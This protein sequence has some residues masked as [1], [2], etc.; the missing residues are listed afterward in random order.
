M[1]F[2]TLALTFFLATSAATSLAEGPSVRV[3]SIDDC[4]TIAIEHNLDIQV[5]Q[6]QPELAGFSLS[7]IYGNYEPSLT[8]SGERAKLETPDGITTE[9]DSVRGAVGGFL[10]WGMNYSVGLRMSESSGSRPG[11]QAD[12]SSPILTTNTLYPVNGPAIDYYGTN[13]PSLATRNPFDTSTANAGFFELRQPLLRDFLIDSTR[14]QIYIDKN[15]LK[16][17]ELELRNQIMLTI[18]E[19]E[20]AYYDLIYAEENVK[21]Q[22][23]ALKLADQL[24]ADNH[25][26][27]E[28]GALAPLDEKQAESQAAASRA[29]LL[30]A[31]AQRD[32]Q[33][34][35]LKN[36]LSD[37]YRDWKDT[38]IEPAEKLKAV[39]QRFDL[40]ASWRTGELSRPALL[41]GRLG[42]E[43]QDEQVK[44]RRN[45]KLPALDLVGDAGY[46]GVG[47]EFSSAFK[48][49]RNTDAPY[50]SYGLQMTIPLGNAVARNN[51]KIAKTT[52]EQLALEYRKLEQEVLISIENSIAVASTSLER[53]DATHQASLYAEEALK[54]EQTKLDKGKSTSFIVLQLQRDL[55]AAR[56]SEIRAL[57]DYNIALARLAFNEGSTLD[58]RRIDLKVK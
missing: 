7:A 1:R 39:P 54:A 15:N 17:S 50:Y 47:Q 53:T 21:V 26:R 23:E 29:N 42:L 35:L 46:A 10:P 14:L 57:A 27:V 5:A 24:V 12:F 3:L 34:R 8:L 33:Q 56:S 22:A 19:V 13:Y 18:T 36:L 44:Y 11:S 43:N 55:T 28:L 45:Q 49:V 30:E 41:L 31:R 4:I 58:R 52:R 2:P 32:T 48:Q 16:G 40:R 6:L 51:Y 20:R 9:T 25:R 37:D 38:T